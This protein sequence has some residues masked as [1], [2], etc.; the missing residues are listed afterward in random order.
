MASKKRSVIPE[1]DREALNG[2]EAAGT[3]A[4]ATP[5]VG[6]GNRRHSPRARRSHSAQEERQS[7]A[8]D[9]S[10]TKQYSVDE[11]RVTKTETSPP[12]GD[13][14]RTEDRQP[15][16]GLHKEGEEKPGEAGPLTEKEK[17]ECER[18][19]KD[20]D[21]R[22]EEERRAPVEEEDAEEAVDKSP[23]GR[24]LK[25]DHEIG[26]G[27]F[28]TVYRGLDTDAGVDVAWC[29]LL[30]SSTSLPSSFDNLPPA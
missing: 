13:S 2:E 11:Q 23:G 16:G 1:E 30:V 15:P 7:P 29:E 18:D 12:G 9:H 28:K 6:Q 24:F 8:R 10:I 27:S 3:P 22:E 19:E 17:V 20:K 4:P 14:P 21:E 5:G 26:R 25:F